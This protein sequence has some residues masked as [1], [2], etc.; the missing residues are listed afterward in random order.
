MGMN[1][2]KRLFGKSTINEAVVN[3]EPGE[4][5]W[6]NDDSPFPSKYNP[7]LIREVKDGW[8]RYDMLTMKDERLKLESFH[9]IYMPTKEPAS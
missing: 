3:P 6:F 5:W 2:L 8:V 4:Y 7:V 9:N 1:I